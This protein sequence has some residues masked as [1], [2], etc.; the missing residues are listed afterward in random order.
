[1]LSF[2]KLRQHNYYFR[3]N[4]DDGVA[5]IDDWKFSPYT[6][7]KSR[8]YIELSTILA[9]F[10]NIQKYHQIKLHFYIF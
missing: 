6:C 3:R 7:F 5:N 8:I 1:M 4:E 9:F 10:F 2:S